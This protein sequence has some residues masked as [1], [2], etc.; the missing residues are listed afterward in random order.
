ML[1][2]SNVSKKLDDFTINNISFHLEPGYI[3]GLIGRNGAGKTTL[4]KLIINAMEKD[5]GTITISGYDNALQDH[6]A[7]SQIGFI[8]ENAPFYM[9][10]SI[11]YNQKLFSRFYTNWDNDCFEEYCKQ[12]KLSPYTPLCNFSK[13]T[14]TKFQLAF[15]LA[16]H[17]KLLLM[18]EPTS[19][20]DPVFRREFLTLLQSIQLEEELS[21]L[22]STHITKDLDKVADYITMIDHGN[23]LFSESKEDLI[24]QYVLVKG[25]IPNLDRLLSILP[26]PLNIRRTS[27]N[28]EAFYE[29]KEL[30]LKEIENSGN[31]L[32]Q[33][34]TIEQIMY[35]LTKTSK[36]RS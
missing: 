12:F 18:D 16:H 10:Y 33:I 11:S 2:L 17:P 9:D 1:T 21:I 22:F 7:R 34:P 6:E 3:M 31:Y 5:S 20:L 23:L 4:I 25:T 15:A 35:H 36:E 29:R 24:E 13:G 19:G 30:S 14:F 28:F 32:L 27:N 26:Y 8:L